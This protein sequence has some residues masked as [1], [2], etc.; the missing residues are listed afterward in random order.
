MD[1]ADRDVSGGTKKGQKKNSRR[2][3]GRPTSAT[4]T[5]LDHVLRQAEEKLRIEKL[6]RINSCKNNCNNN[7]NH[8]KNVEDIKCYI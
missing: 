5:V 8:F 7:N 6:H 2:R 3:K 4:E 1:T